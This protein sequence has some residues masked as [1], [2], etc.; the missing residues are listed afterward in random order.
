MNRP[1]LTVAVTPIMT[2]IALSTGIALPFIAR[3]SHA[4][5]PLAHTAARKRTG[6]AG[7]KGRPPEPAAN[8]AAP[9]GYL[10]VRPLRP[11]PLPRLPGRDPPLGPGGA[12]RQEDGNAD[13]LR[14]RQLGPA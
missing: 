7:Q 8:D 6:A 11:H 1:S 12:D 3:R 9:A 14:Q 10:Y 4:R 2:L 5:E 13:L